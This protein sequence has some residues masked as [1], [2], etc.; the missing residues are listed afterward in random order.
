MPTDILKIFL[1]LASIIQT[2]KD[3]EATVSDVVKGVSFGAD[4]QKS[5][6]DLIG[7]V[8]AGIIVIPGVESAQVSKAIQDLLAQIKV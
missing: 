8:D 1:H 7:L 4:G 3:V 6:S 5:I 2:M